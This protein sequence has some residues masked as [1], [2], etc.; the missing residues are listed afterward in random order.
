[1]N[2][3]VNDKLNFSCEKC[4][5]IYSGYQSLWI[6]NKKYH[7]NNNNIM[8]TNANINNTQCKH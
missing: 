3:K 4:N 2:K 1:M 6:H 7:N 5:K 8:Q